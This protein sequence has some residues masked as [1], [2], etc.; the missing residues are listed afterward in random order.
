[1]ITVGSWDDSSLDEPVFSRRIYEI[2]DS[3]PPRSR[4][5][6]ADQLRLEHRAPPHNYLFRQGSIAGHELDSINPV[7]PVLSQLFTVCTRSPSASSNSN[8][9]GG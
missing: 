2:K 8:T 4:D 3:P 5:P 9:V 7:S 1:M 6:I